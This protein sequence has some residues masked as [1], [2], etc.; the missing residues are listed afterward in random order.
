[1]VLPNDGAMVITIE[2][3][4]LVGSALLAGTSL[5]T[6]TIS[7]HLL[8]SR[9]RRLGQRP[10]FPMLSVPGY[11]ILYCKRV[12]ETLDERCEQLIKIVRVSQYAVFATW[13]AFVVLLIFTH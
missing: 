1:M 3:I 12:H 11:L 6:F 8:H 2:R 9:L 4:L 13:F 5:F 7:S 10:F